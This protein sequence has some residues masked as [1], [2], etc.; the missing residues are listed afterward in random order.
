M[1]QWPCPALQATNSQSL[2]SLPGLI[3]SVLG[4]VGY[5]YRAGEA[6]RLL[7]TLLF[8]F[9]Q[10]PSI[11]QGLLRPGS[12]GGLFPCSCGPWS[13]RAY[14]TATVL[15]VRTAITRYQRLCGGNNGGLFSH[16]SGGLEFQDQGVG[17]VGSAASLLGL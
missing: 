12:G 6:F 1:Q 16:S 14:D 5:S 9:I 10:V 2:G 7:E 3:S 8:S 11:L 4:W 15:F 17:S 13:S